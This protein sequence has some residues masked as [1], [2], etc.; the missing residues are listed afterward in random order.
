MKGLIRRNPGK[1]EFHQAV[2]EVAEYL[3]PYTH[4]H[5]QYRDAQILERLAWASG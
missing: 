5:T 2:R 3:I 4:E 1:P